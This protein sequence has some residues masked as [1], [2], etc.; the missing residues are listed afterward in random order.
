IGQFAFTPAIGKNYKAIISLPGGKIFEQPLPVAEKNGYVMN[1]INEEGG[2][3][4]I[5]LSARIQAGQNG[6]TLLLLV[7]SRSGA[8]ISQQQ[9]ITYGSESIIYI[10]R[11]QLK[12]G[13]NYITLFDKDQ[14]PVCERLVFA[15]PARAITSGL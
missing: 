6:E 12:E 7:H 1:V 13:I 9:K 10:D 15:S 11:S 14:R 5:K 2:R 3:L 8:R 4:K